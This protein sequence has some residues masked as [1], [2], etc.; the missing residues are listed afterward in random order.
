MSHPAATCRS[1]NEFVRPFAPSVRPAVGLG[2]Q[3]VKAR[4]PYKRGARSVDYIIQH[5][6]D[7]S[8]QQSEEK[9]SKLKFYF[10]SHRRKFEHFTPP[11]I[12]G[13]IFF[14]VYGWTERQRATVTLLSNPKRNPK[15]NR[16]HNRK[17][18][19]L[20]YPHTQTGRVHPVVMGVASKRKKKSDWP[21]YFRFTHSLSMCRPATF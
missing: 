9:K 16:K 19:L 5:C 14:A 13:N 20:P 12:R 15:R 4:G 2:G 18:K 21:V 10:R 17:I 8:R 11:A 1:P 6:R 3:I 7:H